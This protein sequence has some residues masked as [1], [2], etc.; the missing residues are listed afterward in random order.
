MDQKTSLLIKRQLPE[1]VREE[2]PLF[3]SFL[4]AYYEFLENKQGTQKN[5]LT[6][7]AKD[8]RHISDVDLS[9]D[10]FEQQFFNTFASA[11]PKDVLIDKATLIKN[12]L[13]IYLSK[14]TE[15]GFKLLFRLL[16]AQ[17]LDVRYPKNEVLRSSSSKWLIENVIKLSETVFTKY[18]GNG[19]SK[20][21]KLAACRCPFT[22]QPLPVNVTIYVN[23][24]L[25]ES[26]FYILRDTKKLV[27]NVAP[28]NGSE[29][30]I[31]YRGFDFN[32]LV[33]RKVTG[34]ISGAY[35]VVEKIS[36][37][38]INNRPVTELFVVER[39]TFGE[40]KQGEDLLADVQD[41]DGSFVNV[42]LQT[43]SSVSAITL[44]NGG[45]SYNVGDPI[46]IS[47]AESLVPATAIITKVFSGTLNQIIVNDGGAGFQ[48][49]TP[50][51]VEGISNTVLD[52]AVSELNSS[53]DVTPNTY[54]FY[55]DFISDVD[56][57][58]TV[59]SANT[60]NFPS[61]NLTEQ[62]LTSVISQTF[63][64]TT[65]TN[66]GEIINVAILLS[67]ISFNTEPVLQAT[68]A[69]LVITPQT[70]N[71]TQN[72]SVS[73]DTFGSLGK[74]IIDDGGLNYV[75][76]DEL[77]FNNQPMSFGIGA[78]A[79]VT[80]VSNTGSITRVEFV[81]SKI[82]G[83]ANVSSNLTFTVT[84]NG[85]IFED[86]LFV[87]DRIMIGN[88]TRTVTEIVSNTS[89]NV[90]STFS[91]SKTLKPIRLFGKNLIGGQGYSQD[92][93]P[94]VTINSNTGSNASI[95]VTAIMGE[96]DDLFGRGTKRPGEIEEVTVVEPGSGYVSLPIIDLT[97]FG[98]GT[99]RAEIVLSPIFEALP[100]RW[101][102]SDSIL[103]SSDRKLQG[104][105]YYSNFTYLTSSQIEFTK[106]KKVFKEL[107]HPVGIQPYAEY[108]QITT[109][110]TSVSIE[111]PTNSN[112]II[113]IS[114][115][116]SIQNG[117]NIVVGT[118]TKFNV[119]NS[120]GIITLGSQ[121]SIGDS[122]RT[123]NS[124]IGNTSLSVTQAFT[125]NLT[126]QEMIIIS[127]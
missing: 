30:K 126:G 112:N 17:E 9:I 96:G 114:G 18:T 68:P 109:L 28:S 75:V 22:N 95:L 2:Y 84:G 78:E 80:A 120:L 118:G 59:L 43:L 55:T 16:F 73:I 58:N 127:T 103:S 87:G 122:I 3:I 117:N 36:N 38:S 32:S 63:A 115:T 124:I 110:D 57:A 44:L 100:G 23:D 102:T 25:I 64:N 15:K 90:D 76:G 35:S 53:G 70:A 107:M 65:Y 41:V 92:R 108:V 13:P 116:V 51:F 33:N 14:G 98:D 91:Q 125:E 106:Y 49:A 29:I 4:E 105:N 11:V 39:N 24:V 111:D 42:T 94:T 83:L 77:I 45:S 113:T 6:K 8:L 5:D 88:E 81:P 52:L 20:E 37:R 31:F 26:G 47:S 21:F 104:R 56:P 62:N 54:T 40:F 7:V 101:T 72:I 121:I 27:F 74:L 85:T 46:V 48:L 89:L 123:V 19:T 10:E 93:L 97:S 99:A 86:E 79:E 67:Q 1:F 60:W 61:S 66:L 12:V 71:T 50:V 34:S 82:T 69:T 119:A